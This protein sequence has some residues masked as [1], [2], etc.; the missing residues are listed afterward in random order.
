MQQHYTS[1]PITNDGTTRKS[2]TINFPSFE[3]VFNQAMLD[4]SSSGSSGSDQL[5]KD[6]DVQGSYLTMKHNGDIEVIAKESELQSPQKDQYSIPASST[7]STLSRSK[8]TSL[9]NEN[10]TLNNIDYHFQ[11]LSFPT[12][13]KTP[14]TNHDQNYDNIDDDELSAT[15]ASSSIRALIGDT[16][17]KSV[18]KKNRFFKRAAFSKK[19]TPVSS[20]QEKQEVD[21][22]LAPEEVHAKMGV[23]YALQKHSH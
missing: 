18:R 8:S 20:T 19:Q 17:K 11:M 23:G 7:L 12:N 16:Y 4:N 3:A 13:S 22:E 15:S 14:C 6:N 21:R 1:W 9:L 10:E 2:E 5:K